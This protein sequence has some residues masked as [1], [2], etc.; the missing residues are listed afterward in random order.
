M[1]GCPSAPLNTVARVTFTAF[2]LAL[3]VSSTVGCESATLP[4]RSLRADITGIRSAHGDADEIG[5][6]DATFPPPDLNDYRKPV[7]RTVAD[8]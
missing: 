7:Y 2:L 8:R 1:N 3:A 4:D 6:L 5:S